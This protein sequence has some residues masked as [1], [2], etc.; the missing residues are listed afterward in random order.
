MKNIELKLC[1]FCQGGAIPVYTQDNGEFTYVTCGNH[2]CDFGTVLS[3]EKWNNLLRKNNRE[4]DE[5]Q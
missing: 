1:P 4:I 3:I 5:I 2:K